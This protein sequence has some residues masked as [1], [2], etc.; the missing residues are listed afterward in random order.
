MA[1]LYLNFLDN[2]DKGLGDK[3]WGRNDFFTQS[4]NEQYETLKRKL[5][6]YAFDTLQE[7]VRYMFPPTP[8]YYN[9]SL[10]SF[11]RV[12]DENKR[13]NK[14]LRNIVIRPEVDGYSRY[15]L[16]ET[17]DFMVIG[18][19]TFG[20]VTEI[21]VKG[22]DL[23][24]KR[25]VKYGEK[26]VF[27][28]SLCAFVK[29]EIYNRNTGNMFSV[30]DYGNSELYDSV[31]TNDFVNEIA[32]KLF[33]VPNPAEAIGIFNQWLR[34]IDFRRYYLGKQSE[35]CEE[36]TD[37]HVCDAYM[38]TKESYRRNEEAFSGLLLDGIKDF[39]KSEQI[40]LSKEVA[41]ADGFPLICVAIE[42]NRKEILS[43]TV[44]RNGKGKPKF[45]VNLNRYTRDAMGLSPY[46]PKSDDKGNIRSIKSYLLGERYLFA[47]IDIEP[48]LSALDKNYEKEL[49]A[50]Y[51][52][53]DSKY[54]G[55]IL[56]EVNRYM[57][58]VSA[59]TQEKYDAQLIE[60]KTELYDRLDSDVINNSDKDV[61]KA[62]QSEITQLITPIETERKKRLGSIR[63]KIDQIRRSKLS[64]AEKDKQI[65]AL[66][67]D[68]SALNDEYD[69]RIEMAKA[70]V[71]LRDHY[72]R[73]N[74][75]LVEKKQ[76]SLAIR[77]QEELDKLKK[78]KKS[79]LEF[80]YAESIDS[81]K[82]EIKNVLLQKLNEDKAEKIENETIRRYQIYFRPQDITDKVKEIEKQIEEI[83]PRYLTYDN[84]A[85]KAK[86]DRQEKALTSI[87]G[88][89]V[90]NPFLPTYLFSPETLA[91]S[92][93]EEIKDPEWCLESLNDRQKLAVKRALQSESIFLLQGPPGT[94]K[95]Q[96]IAE[97]TAQLTKRGKKVL[98]SSETHKAIDNVFDRLPKIPEIRPLRLIPSQNGKETNY[99]P[100]RLVD[101]FYLNICGNLEKQVARYDNYKETRE[102]FDSTM[103]SLRLDYDRLLKLQR[104]NA[105]TERKRNNL[106]L[107][108]N[109]LTGANEVLREKLL[110]AKED[111]EMYTRTLKYVESYRF[112]GDGADRNVLDKYAEQVE[113]LLTRFACFEEVTLDKVAE[114]VNVDIQTINKE[115]E[116]FLSED[117]IVELKNHQRALRN[118]LSSLRDPDTDEAPNEGDLNYE[119][120]K[121]NQS[122]LI[123][124]GKKIKE[125]ENNS[126][127]DIAESVIYSLVPG[128]TGEK[129]ILKQLPSELAQ[130]KVKIADI[131]NK[132]I[133]IIESTLN[134]SI[135]N[136]NAIS[137]EINELK[138][139]I[140]E[141]KRLYEEI[142]E[143]PDI[144]EYGELN[145][146]LKQKITRFFRD[147]GI[148]REYDSDNLE[149]AFDI[150]G[151]EWNKLETEY[152]ASSTENKIKIPMYKDIVKYLSQEDI[153]EED[154]AAYTRELYNS[155]NV[156]GITCTSRDR[157]TPSQL[158]ELGKY[159]IES[160]DIRT[161]GI[162]VVIVDEVSKSS[163][164]D[165]LIPILYGKTV[166]LV[167]DHRQL[168]PMYDLRHMR[169]D[170]FD[171]LDEDKI[172]KEI[173][174]G[175]TKLYEE[176]FF[177][178]LYEKVPSEFRVM[179]NKQYRCHSHIMEV[180][181]HFYGGNGKGLVVGKKQQDDEKEHNLTVKINGNTVI[182]PKRH[183]YFV[184]CDQKESSAFEGSTSKINEQE[185]QVAI[186]LLKELDKAAKGLVSEHKII[187]DPSRKID[188][189]PSAGIICTYGD[190]AGLIKKKR[191]GYQFTGFSGKPDEKL[192]ISTV[193]DFQ[194]D[195]RDIIIVSM[196]RN[197]SGTRY[198]AEFIKKFE[199][200]NVALSRARKLLIIVGSKKF[201]SEAGIID[202]PD[203]EGDHSRDKINFP[204]YREIIDTISFRGRILT[205]KDIL[206]E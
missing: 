13:G 192:V 206:G 119:E 147:F 199:R 183:I 35:R 169:G 20:N 139:R 48:D 38:I 106:L 131:V 138:I 121:K 111:T 160:V 157:F 190:Q 200:I 68:E 182:D 61:Y 44:G 59:K 151:D 196:V 149:T 12:M 103:K 94:G 74:M 67:G 165:L 83:A 50:R 168:P 110:A 202:L 6:G 1:Y 186:T 170:D 175:Y 5:G 148:V 184:D 132:Q 155:A 86:I 82:I 204:V 77:C 19:V 26:R 203:L 177:K 180:F 134:G 89:Y 102:E 153:L 195:E 37:V 112:S 142:G 116:R 24:D 34:Y 52:E 127:F 193:D 130:F 29:K 3:A 17:Y 167:G 4:L 30:P 101:N 45:E 136:E 85:E 108:I 14:I 113:R 41:G 73:R 72:I 18:D 47:Y 28:S 150:I 118:V 11:D 176:C 95:T 66:Y 191:K 205:A 93:V 115:L 2:L 78:E 162:D 76:K 54:N 172:T 98:I 124:V 16:P 57:A 90:K 152:N 174:D 91:Q 87:L 36:I 179:L 105:D 140:S 9:V 84:R 104:E 8:K 141:K 135:N 39:G 133:Q 80:Q 92:S 32:T 128:I 163:F 64:T 198:D 125:Y 70:Q 137:D 156:F 143:N 188:E 181:N 63:S 120:Y 100:E 51:G 69:K 117:A 49:T 194:G 109:R 43:E 114:L 7:F 33:P 40:I 144:E 27:C 62:Y 122:E 96:V 71:S 173:N 154:R 161:Q 185:A 99:S 75:A 65:D 107:E 166:I 126:E 60:Y 123:A 145:S 178:T 171:G 21:S 56:A 25:T 129:E 46:P 97:I 22:I 58:G 23:I 55:I 159:G 79:Q 158:A 189:R 42:K 197:P 201:L 88:G 10:P 164:L 187:V 31:L 53:I 81:E 15:V 146:V